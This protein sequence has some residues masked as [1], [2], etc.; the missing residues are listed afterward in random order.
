MREILRAIFDSKNIKSVR[1][2]IDL[3]R[4]TEIASEAIRSQPSV[5]GEVLEVYKSAPYL[6]FIYLL[7]G[8]IDIQYRILPTSGTL[9]KA[10]IFTIV[11]TMI[12]NV[13]C[14][15]EAYNRFV[16]SEENR[17]ENPFWYAVKKTPR[18]AGLLLSNMLL[19]SMGI[20]AFFIPGVYIAIRSSLSPAI[21]VAEN[22]GIRESIRR[23][24][25]QTKQKGEVPLMV[26]AVNTITIVAL[27]AFILMLSA[28][29]I[30]YLISVV[31]FLSVVPQILHTTMGVLYMRTL[32]NS[33]VSIEA[34]ETPDF[35][36][37]DKKT[38]KS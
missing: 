15:V 16:E 34:R 37:I 22:V 36:T 17:I 27:P 18:F 35:L 1:R 21:C 13:L 28:T 32:S 14:Y 26:G 11:L 8:G 4:Q 33:R 30:I 29:G 9:W 6:L 12:A 2:L 5:F 10:I 20:L 24:F 19:I 3:E 38:W 23:S 31:V 7:I 25:K